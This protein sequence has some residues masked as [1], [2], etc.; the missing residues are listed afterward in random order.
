M[1]IKFKSQGKLFGQTKQACEVANAV[2]VCMCFEVSVF[3]GFRSI[4]INMVLMLTVFDVSLVGYDGG[5]KNPN[6]DFGVKLISFSADSLS[7]YL[8]RNKLSE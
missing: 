2:N 1:R 3:N 8:K 4:P 7:R 5:V 6:L